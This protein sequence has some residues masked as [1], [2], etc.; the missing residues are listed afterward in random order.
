[1]R[2]G[3]V[4][5]NVTSSSANT[6]TFAVATAGSDA[7]TAPTSAVQQFNVR[8]PSTTPLQ[9]VVCA[10]G[11]TVVRTDGDII[12]VKAALPASFTVTATRT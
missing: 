11:C 7:D 3:R 9:Q 4:S 1:M 12:V 10:S 2:A 5:Y 8:V 6:V